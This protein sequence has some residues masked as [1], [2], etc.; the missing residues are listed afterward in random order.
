MLRQTC[1]Y[2]LTNRGHDTRSLQVYLGTEHPAHGLLRRMVADSV[3]AEIAGLGTPLCLS[4][5]RRLVMPHGTPLVLSHETIAGFRRRGLNAR[6]RPPA[7]R[8]PD[9]CILGLNMREAAN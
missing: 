6:S 7:G 4:Y 9:A 1:G 8:T 5:G 3:L 2:A